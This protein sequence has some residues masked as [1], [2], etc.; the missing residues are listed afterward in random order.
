MSVLKLIRPELKELMAYVPDYEEWDYRLHANESPWSPVSMP[1]VAINHYPNDKLRKKLTQQLAAMYHVKPGELVI[2]R[3][4]DEGID[5]LMRLF[6]RA[7]KDSMLQCPPTFPL[8]T[9]YAQ[10][11]QAG[12]INCPLEV[13]GSFTFSLSKL[14]G[15]WQADCKLIMLCRPNNPTNTM[16]DLATISTLCEKYRDQSVIVVDEAYIE[17]AQSESATSLIA[18]FDNLIVLRTLSKAYGMAG[19]RLG[20]VIA[21]APLIKALKA[22]IPPFTLSSAVLNIAHLALKDQDWFENNIRTIISQREK[23]IPKLQNLPL[24]EAVYPSVSNFILLKIPEADK[25]Q[26]WLKQHS[27]AVRHFPQNDALTQMLR[28]T[29]GDKKQNEHLL[30]TLMWFK[31]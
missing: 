13:N 22:I 30:E 14:Y 18:R 16:I 11:Q 26:Q 19:L 8:Y 4:S 23:L 7:G 2:T 27:I 6:I 21:Q 9:F 3:G 24:I 10:L 28:I 12:I 31:K 25:A 1:E 20:A 5:L 17:F 29:V 15:S